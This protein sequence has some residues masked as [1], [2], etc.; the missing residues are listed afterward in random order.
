MKE[1]SA[2]ALVAEVL[3]R[4]PSLAQ[5]EAA[6]QAASARYPQAIALEDPMLDVTLG[7]AT[8]GA[9]TV[10]PAYRVQLSQKYFWPGKRRLRGE[11]AWAEAGA[12]CDDVEDTR[13][14]LIEAARHAFFD[15]Y[16][17]G[18]ALIVNDEGLRLLDEFRKNAQ[19][20]YKTGLAPQQD[21][22]QADVELGRQREQRLV[23]EQN[24][25]IAVAR[26]NTLLNLPPDAPLPPPPER[27]TVEDGLADAAALRAQALANRPDLRAIENRLAADQAALA[28][29]NK[30]F[31]PD[32][33]PFFMYDRFM[34]NVP[35]NEPLAYMLGMSVNLPARRDKR[36]AAVA[37]AQARLN[38]RK[39]VLDKQINQVNFEVQQ[40]YAQVMQGL[41]AVRLY[42]KDVL[43]AAEANVK[44]AQ[45]A[46]QTGKIP[47][48]SLI[49]AQRGVVNLRD[50]Y[51]ALVADYHRRLATLERAV[52]GPLPR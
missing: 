41:Q 39:A 5:M 34:G 9:N 7:P 36:F 14:Q 50:R 13:L 10:N 40:A 31:Y 43:P 8:Y 2:K 11:R 12:A 3:A 48:L 51:Y 15:Y 47:F 35:S 46:Y 29:A 32:F 16:L 22:L 49:E 33:T 19:T 26:I 38:E 45:A 25:M 24:R 21:V 27:L 18:R 17:I 20:R 23:L 28:L 52:G 6:W 44:A 1:L 42:E 4:N 37:E 30:E